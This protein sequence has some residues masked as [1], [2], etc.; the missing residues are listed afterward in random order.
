MAKIIEGLRHKFP[1]SELLQHA[2]MSRSTFYYHLKILN[3]PDKYEDLKIKIKEIFEQNKGYYGYR[4]V[5]VILRNQ[6]YNYNHKT[7]HKLMKTMNLKGKQKKVQYRSY[8]GDV[9][10]KADNIL[11]RQFKAEKPWEK[12]AT[13]VTVFSV[14]DE[15]IYLSPVI[16]L[17]NKEVL[18]YSISKSPN[19][20]QTKD[21]LNKLFIKMPE[22]ARPL[23]HSDQGWQYQHKHYCA[24]LEKHNITQSMSRKGNCLDNSVME[25]FFG[26]L[27]SEMFNGEKFRTVE[28]FIKKLE[29]YICYFNN[30]RVS[31]VLNGMSPVQYRTHSE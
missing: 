28:E 3:N 11:N 12:L 19:F 26:R 2:K 7:I 14:C 20:E 17:F 23:L 30:E 21:M 9:G 8:K 10:K 25:N 22:T 15:K 6:G 31:L 4:R 24:L 13:D 29:E 18:S 27:K 16:D 5:H 1:L